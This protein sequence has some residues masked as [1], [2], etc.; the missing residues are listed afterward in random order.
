MPPGG[1][2]PVA[3]G[4][5]L[6][7]TKVG[8]GAVRVRAAREGRVVVRA[9]L[10]PNG[11]I[12]AIRKLTA[13]HGAV[14]VPLPRDARPGRY[15]VSAV[16]Q[17][18]GLVDRRAVTITLRRPRVAMGYASRVF[19]LR[20]PRGVRAV[21]SVSRLPDGGRRALARIVGPTTR[22]VALPEGLPAG[23][24]RALVSTSGAGGQR[25]MRTISVG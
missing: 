10:L 16:L 19:T 15:R 2:F 9:R 6:T 4:G 14:T 18:N 3:V 7:L 5:G 17:G 20:V 8:R 22:R 1:D 13:P 23:R 21:L 11:R 12:R 25:I 24:Y